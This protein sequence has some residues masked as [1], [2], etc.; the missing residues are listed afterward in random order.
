MRKC[1]NSNKGSFDKIKTN[2]RKATSKVSPFTTN[3]KNR[4]ESATIPLLH[5]TL[6]T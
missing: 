5:I 3:E 6:K 1:R 2:F 4:P